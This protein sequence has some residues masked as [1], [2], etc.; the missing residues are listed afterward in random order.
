M[1]MEVQFGVELKGEGN[2][3]RMEAECKSIFL[4]YDCINLTS[5]FMQLRF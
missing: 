5:Y 1:A 2:R 4:H 3:M